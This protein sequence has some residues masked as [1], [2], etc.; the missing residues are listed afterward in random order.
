MIVL[1]VTSALLISAISLVGRSQSRTQF[2][3]AINDI[4]T[5]LGSVALNVSNGYYASNLA[6]LKCKITSGLP[7]FSAAST[8]DGSCV[9]LGR[10]VQFTDGDNYYFHNVVGRRQAGAP[11]K[12]VSTMSDANPQIIERIGSLA[13][14]SSYPSTSE[15]KIM[16]GGLTVGYM[17][18]QAGG[19][20]KKTSGVA[21]MG[22]LESLNAKGEAESGAQTVDVAPTVVANDKESFIRQFDISF[23]S[24]YG[25]A[26]SPT[27][28][29]SGI[30]ICFDDGATNQRGIVTVGGN[31]RNGTTKLEV[32]SGACS[33]VS[34]L[35]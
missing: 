19:V 22:S 17:A 18:Y 2:T 34:P 8:T 26:G 21:F 29:T 15:T 24:Q 7:Q 33:A 13:S 35:P 27:N 3:Q 4:N 10:V 11:L 28:P 32:Q 16:P 23:G 9:Y 14:T 20:W 1:A 25:S 5:Q 6:G 12:D 30:Q 31:N